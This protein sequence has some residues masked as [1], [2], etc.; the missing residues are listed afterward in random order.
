MIFS[1][2]ESV[3]IIG[4]GLAGCEAAWQLATR[5][6]RVRLWE[7]RP[8]TTTPA[9]RTDNLSE[10][11]CSNSLRGADLKN[12]VGL[13]KEEMR[14]LDSLILKAADRNS[15]PGGGALVVDRDGFSRFVSEAIGEH[16]L[17]NVQREEIASLKSFLDRAQ[18]R[19]LLIATGPLTSPA[20][21]AELARLTD[22]EYLYFYDS[23]APIVD[24]A[25][26]DE[27]IVF[28]ASRY[29]KGEADYLNCPMN[30]EEYDE[31]IEALLVAEKVATKDFEKPKFFEGCLPIEVMAER[32]RKTLAFG[33]MKPVGLLDPRTGKR[34]YAVVQLRQDNLHASL[35]NMVGFQTR[36]KYP[37]QLKVF[38]KIPGL[39]NAEFARLGSMHRNTFINSPRLL[40][41]RLELKK[42][43]GVY[44]AGQ[45]IGVEG[46]V[47]SAAMGLY[48]GI[49]LSR[50]LFKE[51]MPSPSASTALGSLVRHVTQASTQDF[52]P[53]NVNFGLFDIPEALRRKERREELAERSLAEIENYKTYLLGEKE[54]C[55]AMLS[56]I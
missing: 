46:Y 16:P 20:L 33:P 18:E 24:A 48:A 25:S 15:I 38:R 47:E 36:M 9:H 17:I 28:R 13:L 27:Q 42:Y 19:P 44:L 11:V 6:L 37:D 5:G 56:K 10:L 39:N 2:E 29:D 31:F 40:N 30:Q 26:V 45:M 43:P 53:M 41:E 23:I 34:P 52:Q 12:A 49:S 14:R 50:R 22:S 55:Q 21:S 35:Y 7:M 3:N 54:L 51:A 1:T 8:K 32:G 4:G